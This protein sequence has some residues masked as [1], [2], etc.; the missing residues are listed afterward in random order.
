MRLFNLF[1]ALLLTPF[2]I[3]AQDDDDAL[4]VQIDYMK[5]YENKMADYVWMER[6][7]YK[8]IHQQRINS[9]E[10][11]AWQ[12]YE[13][14]YPSGS[15]T[16]Y[17]YVTVTIFANFS[18]MD[19]G[20]VEYE[21][22]V[23]QAHPDK[24]LEEVDRYATDT[25]TLVRSEVFKSV[26]MLP[27]IAAAVPGSVLVDY[28]KVPPMHQDQYIRME[29]EIWKPLHK[30]RMVNGNI[31]SWTLYEVLFPGGLN[32][33]YSHATI[34]GFENWSKIK[35]S[36]PDDVWTKVHPNASQDELENR[37]HETRDLVSSQIWKLIDYTMAGVAK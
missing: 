14:Q 7:I 26:D 22:L 30:E 35:D 21:T 3:L 33:P 13:V 9:G 8:P 18:S 28:M 20:V 15:G 17:N 19:E 10:I 31:L 5:P 34:T 29:M 32:H 16:E 4:Y 2:F 36:W 12:L 23:A 11:V 6:N 24:T 27:N 37:A 1:L 25:R